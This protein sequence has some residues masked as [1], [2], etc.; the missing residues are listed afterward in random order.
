MAIN[1]NHLFEDLGGIKCS[2]VEKNAS[3]ARVGFLRRILEYNRYTVIVVP[4][5]PPKPAAP[6]AVSAAAPA[7]A[8]VSA[9]DVPEGPPI[10]PPAPPPSAA[11]P[12]AAAP[13]PETFTVG[14]TDT[15]FNPTNA[16]FG[17]LLKAPGGHVVT[18]AYWQQK[19]NE[20]DDQIPYFDSKY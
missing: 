20:P 5:P 11:P 8:P 2:I 18:L 13:I 10:P 7:T 14:V 16:I 4:S 3:P 9:T 12:P 6:A 19:E 17:R 1:Q 15:M